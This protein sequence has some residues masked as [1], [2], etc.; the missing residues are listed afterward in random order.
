MAWQ[1]LEKMRA[2]DAPVLCT[3]TQLEIASA[4]LWHGL[5]NPLGPDPSKGDP[6]AWAGLLLPVSISLPA[7]AGG[8]WGA[9]WAGAFLPAAPP[10]QL[11]LAAE[12]L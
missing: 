10:Q 7:R 2:G 3:R 11:L 8:S 1:S 12:G 9:G 4:A 6:K 5:A